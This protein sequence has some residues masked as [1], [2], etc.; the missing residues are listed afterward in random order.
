MKIRGWLA[1]PVAGIL[2]V[3]ASAASSQPRG[4]GM[5]MPRYDKASETRL[6][7]TV[8]E[9]Q[10]VGSA[11]GAGIH[12]VLTT[13]DG[14]IEVHVGPADWL[15]SKHYTFAK[16]DRLEILGARVSEDSKTFLIARQI[17][18]GSETLILRDDAGVPLWAGRHS[19]P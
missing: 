2:A 17:T 7:G 10:T 12:L 6:G 15:A 18:R 13:P 16:G 3:S 5:G 14:S 1:A 9:V 11:G 19:G 4:N 8:A